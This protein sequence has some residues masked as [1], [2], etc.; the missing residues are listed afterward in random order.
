[1]AQNYSLLIE[2]ADRVMW[3][4]GAWNRNPKLYATLA[5]DD[6]PIS[7]TPA[8]KRSLKPM[9]NF[10]SNLFC[11]L[12]SA[13]TLRLYHS[14][15][16]PR[17]ADPLLGECKIGIKELLRQC[18]SGQVV[19]LNVA[20]KGQVSGRL[21][22]RLERSEDAAKNAQERMQATVGILSP[23]GSAFD[24]VDAAV[25][26]GA[27]QNDLATALGAC[28]DRFDVFVK[29]GDKIAQAHPYLSAAWT[30]LT[31]VYQAVKQQREMD[32]EVVDLVNTM[33]EVYS[34]KEDINFVS[35]KIKIL[36]DSLT[37]IAQKT[38]ARANFLD[39]Y[40][41]HGFSGRALRA[42]F[43]NDN[44]KRIDD[45]SAELMKLSQSFSYALS[46][47]TL[48]HVTEIRGAV[49]KLDQSGVLEKLK[50]IS[51]DA[52]LR[53]ECL[54]GTREDILDDIFKWLT[55]PSATSN[56]LW[57]SGVAGSGKSSIATSLSQRFRDQDCLGAFIFFTRNTL[58][59]S[60]PTAVLHTIAY[61]LA[62]FN[63]QIR[64][65][66]CEVIAQKPGIVDVPIRSQ[67]EALLRGPLVSVQPYMEKPI[68]IILDALD[69][70]SDENW[71]TTL[72]SLIADDFS[73]LPVV[74]RFL[75]TSRP[76]ADI[77]DGD[78]LSLQKKLTGH[79]NGVLSVA[80]SPDGRRIVSGSFD[81]TIR[82]WDSETG[83]A[84]GAPWTGHS[85]TVW[86]VAFSPD[87][88]QI[89]SGSKDNTIHIWDSETGVAFSPDGRRIVSG[90]SD[91]TIRI[92]D[93]QTGAALGA[94]L[95]GHR[96]KVWSVAFSPD[97]RWI[98]S[99]SEDN[100]LRIW[101]SET[102]AALGAPLIGHG[103]TVLS[104]AFS[105]DG[106]QIVSGSEDNTIRIWDSNPSSSSQ[107]DESHSN[108]PS[109]LV[110]EEI[111]CTPENMGEMPLLTTSSTIF[112]DGWAVDSPHRLIWVPAWLCDHF[113]G[114]H[115][116]FVIT[117][118]GVTKL[119][120]TNFVHGTDWE[121]CIDP[122]VV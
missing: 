16:I 103:D 30:I 18:G 54:P 51:Y 62:Q 20:A 72:I 87:G 50:H 69:E 13:I 26:A 21:S 96:H 38:L 27:V 113:C 118:Q 57:L 45:L 93:S 89:V 75:I 104:V 80:F 109:S 3:D 120:L 64:D 61:S 1:M 12:R 79:S 111:Y 23:I 115:N 85:S 11:P 60:N 77:T 6:S 119:D 47:Q 56:I 81:N 52:S 112:T 116:L 67:F 74:F 24:K 29:M 86:A 92:W 32:K 53:S 117:P 71:R 107:H 82:I 110:S 122:P 108:L 8:F 35:E 105:P 91:S 121:K 63:A 43:L 33:V 100:T 98:V 19:Q 58:A 76:D 97:G 48:S 70:C 2:S 15:F 88:R 10:S 37:K 94:P 114:P 40:R 68:V 34:F 22:V 36:E 106:R 5:L 46:V 99:G 49:K 66:L 31:S 39:E 84:L 95:T 44:R 83:A 9:W 55:T 14:T 25:E 78:W 4:S 73:T 65:A 90:S 28:V 42:A 7:K 101:D 102:G 17:R 41:R 59:N